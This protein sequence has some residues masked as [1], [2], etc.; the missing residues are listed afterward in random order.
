METNIDDMNPEIYSYVFERFLE[1]GALDLY[2]TPVIMKKNRPGTK[3]SLLVTKD[4]VEKMKEMLFHETT[5]LG[6][7]SLEVGREALERKWTKK[8]TPLGIVTFKEGYYQG[9]KVKA[10]PEYEECRRI[11]KEQD[12]PLRRVYEILSNLV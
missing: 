3:L 2:L 5:T 6:I 9:K 8:E 1:E 10:T 4:S 11:A 7:R 12:L